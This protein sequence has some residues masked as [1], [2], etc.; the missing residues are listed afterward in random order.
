M[1][2][3]D[4]EKN[5]SKQDKGIYSDTQSYNII[6]DIFIFR[7]DF[8]DIIHTTIQLCINQLSLFG[9]MNDF[10]SWVITTFADILEHGEHFFEINSRCPSEAL[11][12]YIT[13]Q[14]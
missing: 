6:I 7:F 1:L 9:F 11:M 4:D 3:A 13:M 12:D 8:T 2:R 5:L 10:K 14:T